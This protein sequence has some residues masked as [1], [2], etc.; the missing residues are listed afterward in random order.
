MYFLIQKN[1][2]MA[3]IIFANCIARRS[4]F[5][6]KRCK[7]ALAKRPYILNIEARGRRFKELG[8]AG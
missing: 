5:K 4:V 3:S 2:R 8:L 6:Y 1:L 7:P